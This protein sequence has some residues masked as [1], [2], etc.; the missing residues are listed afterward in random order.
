MSSPAL[1]NDTILHDFIRAMEPNISDSD[2]HSF[3]TDFMSSETKQNVVLSQRSKAIQHEESNEKTVLQHDML[4]RLVKE[5]V[6][7]FLDTKYNEHKVE[8]Q[9]ETSRNALLLGEASE[10]DGM[11]LKLDELALEKEKL[12]QRL[13]QLEEMQA[14][15]VKSSRRP[16]TKFLLLSV[17]F[18][19]ISLF[20]FFLSF[21]RKPKTSPATD[22]HSATAKSSL[23]AYPQLGLLDWYKS[24]SNEAIRQASTSARVNSD[25][26]LASTKEELGEKR[27]EP[28]TE[29]VSPLERQASISSHSST[30]ASVRQAKS[31]KSLTRGK[32]QHDGTRKSN[33]ASK[34][35]SKVYFGEVY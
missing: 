25:I 11:K 7:H 16:T 17:V 9:L 19:L 29:Q 15:Q 21:W 32:R 5:A 22:L 12:N 31:R 18:T 28:K 33:S 4:V 23:V 27:L 6:F 35:K 3:V 26:N 24:K 1:N 30:K 14:R 2:L 13:E 20:V 10:L 8:D 34:T